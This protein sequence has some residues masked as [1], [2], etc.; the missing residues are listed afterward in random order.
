MTP[1]RVQEYWDRSMEYIRQNTP[2]G[3]LVFDGDPSFGEYMNELATEILTPEVLAQNRE[4][5][6][7]PSV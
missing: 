5:R 3:G 4:A 2:D 7:K 6:A 1:E